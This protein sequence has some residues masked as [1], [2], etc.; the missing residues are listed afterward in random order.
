MDASI[1]IPGGVMHSE[2]HS[3]ISLSTLI[4]SSS[5]NILQGPCSQIKTRREKPVTEIW[6]RQNLPQVCSIKTGTLS[7]GQMK[8]ANRGPDRLV[9][10]MRQTLRI[11][12]GIYSSLFRLTLCRVSTTLA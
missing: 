7:L 5:F 4:A 6:G 8:D 2:W 9:S 10:A 11:G 3:A 12:A 1:P